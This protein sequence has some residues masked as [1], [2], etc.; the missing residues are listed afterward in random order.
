MS[1]LA[2]ARANDIAFGSV[3]RSIT[4]WDAVLQEP[5]G[6]VHDQSTNIDRVRA[7]L[8][9]VMSTTGEQTAV[10][11]DD[12]MS[13]QLPVRATGI[14]FADSV[15]HPQLQVCDLLAGAAAA[16]AQWVIDRDRNPEYARDLVDAGIESMSLGII[17]P[18]VDDIAARGPAPAGAENPLD[19]MARLLRRADEG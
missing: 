4:Y 13:Y 18:D 15:A 2:N 6:V 17:I 9:A 7:V 3:F 10:A 1:I 19:V 8:E 5:F 16:L 11:F 12:R 14:S